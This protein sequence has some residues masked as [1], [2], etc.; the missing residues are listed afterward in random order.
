VHQSS[1]ISPVANCKAVCPR[2][3]EKGRS[4]SA[5]TLKSLL[6]PAAWARLRS[7]AGFQFC[8]MPKCDVAYF[9]PD[10]RETVMAA[11]VRVPI[12][13][14]GAEPERLVCYCFQ[15]TVAEIQQ[16]VR[17]TG[18][19]R[20]ATDIKAKCARGQDD[21]AH[22]NPQGSCCLGN[23]QRVIREAAGNNQPPSSDVGDCCCH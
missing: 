3:G 15:H 4:V 18:T 19:S 9:H 16:E 14:K 10:S 1:S 8:A 23:V 5:T 6:Q 13:Q 17:A 2:C 22:T 7:L 11:E 12:F 21:C 20:I